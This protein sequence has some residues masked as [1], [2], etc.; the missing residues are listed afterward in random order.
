M[1]CCNNGGDLGNLPVLK[2][3]SG[4]GVGSDQEAVDTDAGFGDEIYSYASENAK[5]ALAKEKD[6]PEKTYKETYVHFRDL[7]KKDGGC[8]KGQWN[9]ED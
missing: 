6:I 1:G 8:Y 9:S 2:P 4:K 7:E 3:M 5:K